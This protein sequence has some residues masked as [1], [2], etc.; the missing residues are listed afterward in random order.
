MSG[1]RLRDLRWQARRFP[2]A[3]PELAK[4]LDDSQWKVEARCAGCEFLERRPTDLPDGAVGT[5]RCMNAW[6]SFNERSSWKW[7]TQAVKLRG[8]ARAD[9]RLLGDDPKRYA[10]EVNPGGFACWLFRPG[11]SLSARYYRD[12]RWMDYLALRA[13]AGA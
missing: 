9:C 2:R 13:L 8:Y 4:A 3:Y 10:Y 5:W 1:L 7:Y 11:E 6:H 12:G